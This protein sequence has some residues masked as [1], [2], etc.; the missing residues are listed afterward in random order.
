MTTESQRPKGREGAFS[1]LDAAIEAMNHAETIS[2]IP[3]AKAAFGSARDLLTTIRVGFLLVYV[4][5]LL[6]NV[7]TG[8]ND[9]QSELRRTGASLR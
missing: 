1:S 5:R 7:Y 8:F 9:Q 6:A 4:G 3:P 2:S